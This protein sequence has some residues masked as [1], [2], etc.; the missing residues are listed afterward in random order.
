MD[1]I[2]FSHIRWNFVYQR[3]QHLLNR[4][5]VHNRVFIIEEPVLD[6]EETFYEIE[7]DKD[8]NLW[9]V[10]LHVHKYTHPDKRNLILKYLINTFLAKSSVISYM[11]WYYSP[12]SLKY[13][14][15]LNPAL[16]IYDCMDELSAFKFAPPGVKKT[17]T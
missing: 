13:S 6:A 15:H 4:F 14:D 12:M 1:L 9:I 16:I 10:V 11:L 8:H 2:C 17:R 5:A 7:K 3:P